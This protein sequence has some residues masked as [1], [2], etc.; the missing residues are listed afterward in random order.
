ML[1]QFWSRFSYDIGIDL[2]TANTLVY[3][4]GKGILVR[5]PTVVAIH[6]KTKDI[7]AVGSEAKRMIGKTPASITAIR[8]LRDGVISDF[9]VTQKML[10]YYLKLVHEMPSQF[11]KLPR[12]RVVL[13]VPQGVTS[14][15]RKAVVDAA[16]SAGAREAFLL[17]EPMAAA[18][19]IGLPV[20]EAQGTMI[21]DMG[22]GTS[23][24]A[25]ISL[26]GIVVNKSLRVAGD[27]LDQEIVDYAKNKYNLLLGERTAEEIKFSIGNVIEYEGEAA[28][29]ALF[30][31]RDL[32]SGLPRSIEISPAE[33]REALKVP[34]Y[35]IID[36]IKDA[37]EET[38]AELVSDILKNGIT[39]AGG[40]SLL[41]GMDKLMSH[42]LK[43]PVK[44]V[45][46]PM[47]CVVRGCGIVLDDRD[48]LNKV[49]IR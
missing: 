2:G 41:R 25:V 34:V 21:V 18:I 19:G 32:K 33:I 20:L 46:D 35:S 6:K 38:P 8:P 4:K 39:L 9:T 17:D 24:I 7:L 47:T 16:R 44:V 28:H 31:G 27:E 5:E 29:K 12:P 45:P 42:E 15:E 40:T 11:P 13:G 37:I 36:A 48:L 3:V 1:N 30:R 23:E 22:G 49:R 14:V 10:E 26:G 43:V